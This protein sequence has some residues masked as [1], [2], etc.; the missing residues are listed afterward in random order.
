MAYVVQRT[1]A[2]SSHFTERVAPFL[3]KKKRVPG[4]VCSEIKWDWFVIRHGNLN[5]KGTVLS[6]LALK[7]TS[8]TILISANT[9]DLQSFKQH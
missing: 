2:N 6:D 8:D 4:Q 5:K 1:A 7:V 9:S 3:E